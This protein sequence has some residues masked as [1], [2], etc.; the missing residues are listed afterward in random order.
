M[1]SLTGP[2]PARAACRGAP[3]EWFFPAEAFGVEPPE[4]DPRAVELCER[5]SERGVCFAWAVATNSEGTFGGTSTAQRRAL[6]R[7]YART[8]CPVC[9]EPDGVVVVGDQQ[10]CIR[11]AV[12][13]LAARV[14]P[15]RASRE[16]APSRPAG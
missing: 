14:H 9:R 12:A 16:R 11:C 8:L 13:W 6:S 5:C 7:R 15:A 3:L 2:D 4:P 10:V 1:A